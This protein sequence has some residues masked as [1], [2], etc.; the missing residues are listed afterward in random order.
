[1]NIIKAFTQYSL[2][3]ILIL[4]VL[5]SIYLFLPKIFNSYFDAFDKLSIPIWAALYSFF[6]LKFNQQVKKTQQQILIYQNRTSSLEK[7]GNREYL[8]EYKTDALQ[9]SNLEKELAELKLHFDFVNEALRISIIVGAIVKV[10]QLVY[11]IV[12]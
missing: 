3:A 2:Y 5:P 9:L 10:I 4:L 8:N 6:W 7:V 1:M 11:S 12:I